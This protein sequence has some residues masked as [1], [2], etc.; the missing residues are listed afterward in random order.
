MF[1]KK[2][3]KIQRQ[4]SVAQCIFGC[5]LT[6]V[7]QERNQDTET[8]E[9]G[10]VHLQLFPDLCPAR[11]ESKYSDE[12]VWHSASSAAPWAVTMNQNTVTN[13]WVTVLLGDRSA[14]WD[15][16]YPNDCKRQGLMYHKDL[17]SE[18]VVSTGRLSAV[19]GRSLKRK[20]KKLKQC[21]LPAF[22]K[23]NK[24]KTEKVQ[25]NAFFNKTLHNTKHCAYFWHRL[26]FQ[27]I[28][29]HFCA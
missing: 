3:I 10:T 8:N 29:R 27:A 11:E 7:Q 2:G 6:Y 1:N 14:V 19:R 21:W 25:K 17:C 16:A 15:S 4:T 24:I 9:R 22:W 12:Q 20:T 23:T 18:K 28:N 26:L 5:F 13:K